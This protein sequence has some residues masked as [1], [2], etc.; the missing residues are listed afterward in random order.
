MPDFAGALGASKDAASLLVLFIPSRDR[1]NK[2]IEQGFWVEEAL[3][4]LGTLFGGATAFPQGKGVWRDDAQEGKLLFD[5]PVV[6]Q[7]YTSEHI[8]EQQIK[9]LSEFVH[10]MGHEARQGAIGL[11]IDGDYLEIGFPLEE[12]APRRRPKSGKRR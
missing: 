4:V 7:C 9:T 1:G 8:I 6:M 5:E 2:P 11:V 10:R 3:K 12:A